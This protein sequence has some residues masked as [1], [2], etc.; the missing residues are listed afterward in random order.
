MRR[1]SSG[2]KPLKLTEVFRTIYR[3]GRWAHGPTLSV[4][5]LA[6]QLSST[7]IGM[8]TSRGVKGAVVRNR[9]RRQLRAA[10]F[11]GEVPLRK[12]LDILIV[13]HPKQVP[14]QHAVLVRELKTLCQRTGAL[15]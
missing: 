4:G 6:N 13:A 2:T 11:Q 15:P 1:S 12:G 5:A 8:R 9:I 14:T 3:R 10:L 7:R